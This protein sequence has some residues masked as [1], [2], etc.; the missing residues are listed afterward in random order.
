MG[1]RSVH[2]FGTLLATFITFS[3][4]RE[5]SDT[6]LSYVYDKS[7]I[8]N[9][10]ESNL[11]LTGQFDAIWTA[12]NCNYQIWDYEA[13]Y[14]IDWDAVYYKYHNIFHELDK[15]YSIEN[16]IP[17]DTLYSLYS[18]IMNP[19]HDGHLYLDM[20]NIFNNKKIQTIRPSLFRIV[21]RDDFSFYWSPNLR[22][23]LDNKSLYKIEENIEY[24]EYQFCRFKDNILYLRLTGPITWP[25][26]EKTWNAWF[27]NIQ[28]LHNRGSLKGVILDL[29]NC[30]GGKTEDYKYLLG[31]LIDYNIEKDSIH[32]IGWLRTKKGIGRLDFSPHIP[33][34]LPV[35]QEKHVFISAE[36]IV[37]LSNCLTS[38]F[39]EVLCY[40]AKNI[41]NACVIGK[42]TWG[43]LNVL[44]PD[45]GILYYSINYSGRVGN[46]NTSFEIYNPCA[47][48][49]T[50][51]GDILEG[52]GIEPD[53]DISLDKKDTDRD[54][55]LER[56]LE[57]VLIGK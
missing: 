8:S 1:K 22:Y 30:P 26:Y 38:S 7:D 52:K 46:A 56:A 14:N 9:F 40:E 20:K 48:F 51:E 2:I 49:M 57:Y 6:V 11:S 54:L 16:P 39:A 5:D 4:C 13:E 25:S 3:S 28:E 50:I 42:P 15:I 44:T 21:K 34:S 41:P 23:Y 27:H 19:L 18:D 53:I 31:A 43:C 17:N 29:R 24:G 12:L 45:S 32:Q 47:A 36:P 35:M 37:I 33:F 55:Q 10:A